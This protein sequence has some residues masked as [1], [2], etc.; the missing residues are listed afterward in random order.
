M[1]RVIILVADGVGCGGAPDA[2]TYGDAGADTLGNLARRLGGLRL[3]NLAR[4]GLGRTTAIAGVSPTINPEGA[5]GILTQASAGKD[6][7]TGHWEMAGLVTTDPMATFPHGFPIE[8][9]SALKALAGRPLIGNKP[10]SGTAI[11][12]ELGAEHLKSGALILYT[13]ADSVLQIAAHEEIVPLPELFRICQAARGIADR[14]R[15]GRVIA[16]PFVGVPGQFRRTYNRRDFSMLPP[17]PTLCDVLTAAQIPVLGVGKIADIFAGRG[18]PISLHTEGNDDGMNITLEA[19]D[20]M[21]RGLLFVNLVDFDMVFGHRNDC[22]GFGRA[23]ET[24]DAWLPR[25]RARLHAGDAAFITADHGN[26][27]TTAG[28]DHTRERV[29]LLAFGPGVRPATT[30]GIRRSFCDL[31]QTVAAA[32]GAPALD[33]GTSFWDEVRA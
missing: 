31:G 29:P 30:I 28:T 23:L 32:L 33:R 4:L 1:G 2:S 12:E 19:L 24:F 20:R 9:T 3:P 7:I 21:D 17:R 26:D 14:H 8:I 18:V 10:A 16:R 25:F 11:I 13:S 22:P 15:I 5:W 27:P 6:T